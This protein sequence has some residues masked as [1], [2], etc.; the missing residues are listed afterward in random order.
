[1]VCTANICRSPAAEEITRSLAS[2]ANLDFRVEVDSAGVAAF[3]HE[4]EPAD[5]RMVTFAKQRGY[6]IRHD[7]RPVLPEDISRFDLI[8]YMQHSHREILLRMAK[9]E[10]LRRK[11]RPLTDYCEV[12]D[13]YEVPDPYRG[14]DESFELV[15]DILED[16]AAGLITRLKN[17]SQT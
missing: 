11:I 16:A 12:H 13:A 3:G 2:K 9:D 17:Q 8:L 5:P 4:G 6:T 10:A 14:G 1:M 7:A 15:L